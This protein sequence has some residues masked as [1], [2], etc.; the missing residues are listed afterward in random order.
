MVAPEG[1]SPKV[2]PVTDGPSPGTRKPSHRFS[3]SI[4]SK[5]QT[6]AS[7]ATVVVPLPHGFHC[8]E[9]D[10]PA[11]AG[12][13][14]GA[15][16]TAT[17][18]L[19]VMADF[20]KQHTISWRATVYEGEASEPDSPA[21]LHPGSCLL[22]TY[23]SIQWAEA[24]HRGASSPRSSLPLLEYIFTQLATINES[25]C[26]NEPDVVGAYACVNRV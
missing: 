6:K 17:D 20:S 18:S 26:F 8:L 5:T 22:Y 19:I 23:P 4:R 12:R 13:P 11:I 24:E 10:E 14:K 16:N 9:S 7:M 15:G 1:S 21:A 2:M 25:A 3:I